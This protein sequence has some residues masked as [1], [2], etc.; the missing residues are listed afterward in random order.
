[1]ID[2][3]K[4]LTANTTLTG[5][6]GD[7]R[8]SRGTRGDVSWDQRGARML[9]ALGD[10]AVELDV[11]GERTWASKQ[12]AR[13]MARAEPTN[14]PRLLPAFD[15]WVVAASA[16]PQRCSS[17]ATRRASTARKAGSRRWCS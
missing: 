3:E 1:M 11:E 16:A 2:L 9:A 12:S 4:A 10:E 5:K 7:P 6:E 8:V 17:Q 14:V 13:E 15:P